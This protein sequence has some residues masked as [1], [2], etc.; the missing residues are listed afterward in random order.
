MQLLKALE[1][2]GN[3]CIQV[4]P[5]EKYQQLGPKKYQINPTSRQEFQQLLQE[6]EGIT[7]IVHLWGI[8]ELENKDS[9]ELET[10]LAKNCGSVLHLVQG[11]IKSKPAQNPQ[12]WLITQGTQKV[13]SN[14]EVTNPE[15]GS[16]WALG[17]VLTLEHPE[18]KCK[19]IDIDP[20]IE[21]SQIGDFL[22]A[23]LLSQEVEDQIAIRK[24]QR[25]VARLEQKQQD[26]QVQPVQ[27]KLAE[28]GVIDNL[29]WEAMERRTPEADEIEIEV[30]TVGLNFRDV[31]NA[32]GLLKEYYAKHL[33]ITSVEQLKFGFECAGTISAVGEE[34]SQWQVGDKVIATMVP[35]GFSSFV[36][37]KATNIIPLPE[38]MSFP[39]AATLPLTFLTAYYG[40]QH[41]AK[42]Q[43]GE[44]VL[45]HAAA[46]GVG[47]AAVQIAQ[48]AGAQILATASPSKWDFLKSLGIE[49][50]MN[51]R[52]LDFSQE[53]MELTG[54]EG[55]D[56]VL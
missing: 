6:N 3:Q 9:L 12:L 46:G 40:L 17:Q 49:H 47:Q 21:P 44:R 53:I 32:L 34:V 56:V 19:R 38:K 29:K 55:V 27:L 24:G 26:E 52:T 25:Y 37:T 36:T 42:I 16:L 8:K 7:G 5:G 51:S 50:V 48:L 11:I 18:L 13:L 4:L 33:G 41:L 10:I 20:N 30:A 23:E 31:L 45:I 14:T 22:E 1:K 15:Y 39:E 2:K 35:D 43:P 28:Y 54:G